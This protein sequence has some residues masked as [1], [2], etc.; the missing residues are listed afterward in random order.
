M[1]AQFKSPHFKASK[2]RADAFPIL[3]NSKPLILGSLKNGGE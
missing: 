1:P 3:S 2:T